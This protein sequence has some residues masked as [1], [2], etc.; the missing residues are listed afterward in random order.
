VQS[1]GERGCAYIEAQSKMTSQLFL[2]LTASEDNFVSVHFCEKAEFDTIV[3]KLAAA[4]VVAIPMEGTTIRSEVALYRAFASA[5][6]MPKGWYGD[7]EFA[8]NA[9]AFLEYLDDVEEWIPANGHVVVIK[10]SEHLWAAQPRIAGMLVELWQ[11]ATIRRGA[12][13]RLVF[14]W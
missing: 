6:R 3:V 2:D 4:N 9:N 13:S 14:V 10:D 5:L 8:P 1:G 11:A 12:K 7:K